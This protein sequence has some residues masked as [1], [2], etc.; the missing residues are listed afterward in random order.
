[1][2]EVL[3]YQLQHRPLQQIL[4]VLLERTLSRGWRAVLLAGSEA[5]VEELNAQLWSYRDDSF[6]PHG[7]AQDGNAGAQPVYLTATY[8]NPNR[9]NVLFLV[10]GADCEHIG[11][12]DRCVDLFDGNDPVALEAARSRY[13]RARTDGHAVT[14]WQQSPDGNWQ[15]QN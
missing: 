8:E 13:R 2:S 3:F 10:D 6:L 11:E 9:A 12:F 5:R 7:G 1:M 14:Y 4:P 15:Q